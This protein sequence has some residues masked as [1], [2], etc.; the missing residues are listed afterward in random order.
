MKAF[1]RV[2]SDLELIPHNEETQKYVLNR[3]E[4]DVISAQI[5]MVRNYGNHKRFFA[6]IKT[7]Y[8]M[9]D[10][11]E[12]MEAY[13]YWLTL[14]CGWFD[15]VIAPNGSTMFKPRSISFEDMEEDEFKRLFSTAI[16]VF[17]KELGNGLTERELMRVI[18][19]D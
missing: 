12:Q 8:D 15:T 9:Q 5:K 7:T 14:K 13:R 6:F 2:S 3:K 4:G 1:F 16:D 19:F 18:N 11:F 17:L 10:H